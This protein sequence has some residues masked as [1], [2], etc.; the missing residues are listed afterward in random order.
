[1]TD[2]AAAVPLSS[3]FVYLFPASAAAVS[4]FVGF[5]FSA[6]S[7]L[8]GWM[9]HRIVN[10]PIHRSSNQLMNPSTNQPTEQSINQSIEPPLD[11]PIHTPINSLINQ[12]IK[13]I[14]QP[15]N[16]S[17]RRYSTNRSNRLIIQPINQTT[18]Q[19]TNQIDATNQPINPP[20]N[21]ATNHVNQ[22]CQPINEPNPFS[23]LPDMA[24][25]ASSQDFSADVNYAVEAYNQL[26]ETIRPQGGD[27]V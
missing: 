16:R 25:F 6:S 26:Q 23:L 10:E 24:D 14:A 2:C 15:I 9:D 18:N 21:H 22:S 1:M 11:Q 12:S 27:M 19:P 13:L 7:N 5:F 17:N 3:L 8:D 4:A 20:T